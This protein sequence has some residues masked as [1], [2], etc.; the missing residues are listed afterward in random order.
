MGIDQPFVAFPAACAPRDRASAGAGP[1]RAGGARW[2][3]RAGLLKRA[4]AVYQM[5]QD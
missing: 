4:S 1:V 3:S 5:G 2:R